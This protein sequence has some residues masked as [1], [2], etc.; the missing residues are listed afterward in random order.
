MKSGREIDS[1]PIPGPTRYCV[2]DSCKLLTASPVPQ[3]TSGKLC[4]QPH[5]EG[6]FVVLE[7]IRFC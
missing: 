7:T 2:I 3:E 6:L 1:W 4:D 5:S